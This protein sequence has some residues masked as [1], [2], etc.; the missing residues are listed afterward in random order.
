MGKEPI[1]NSGESDLAPATIY[2]DEQGKPLDLSEWLVGVDELG[3]TGYEL[4]KP[5]HTQ[6][7]AAA[8][9]E[10]GRYAP[11]GESRVKVRLNEAGDVVHVRGMI[12]VELKTACSRCLE[13]VSLAL[14]APLEL[15][16]FAEGDESQAGVD[17][18]LGGS[19]VGDDTMDIGTYKNQEIQVL[20]L[21]RDELFLA[22]P[23]G[24]HCEMP[25]SKVLKSCGK[26]LLDEAAQSGPEVEGPWDALRNIKLN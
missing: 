23:I 7:L 20:D 24:T 9:A 6:W 18:E 17:G 13:G 1:K 15:Y 10:D 19:E 14:K 3:D 12:A 8:L 25:G 21:V 16:L 4:D 11:H 26:S 22:L 5:I 2:L